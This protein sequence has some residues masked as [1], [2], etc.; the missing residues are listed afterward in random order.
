MSYA[1]LILSACSK[2]ALPE[3]TTKALPPRHEAL[4]LIQHYMDNIFI[5]L[6]L[7]EESS[8]FLA[9]DNTYHSDRTEA[10]ALDT[11]NVRMVLAI[12]CASKSRDRGDA[13]YLDA[14]MH[15]TGALANAEQ[16]LRPGSILSVQAL[17]LLVEYSM[18]DPHHFDSWS[19]VGAASRA[20]VDLGLH[21]DPPR[22]TS[23]TKAKLELRR[24]VY[25]CV[26]AL[27]RS[28]SMVQSRAFSFSDDSANVKALFGS[29][30]SSLSTTPSQPLWRQSFDSARTL[31]KLR[32]LQSAWYTALFQTSRVP[33]PEPYPYIWKTCQELKNWF[34]T[35]SPLIHT[36]MRSFFELELLYSFIY[37]LSP[38]SRVPVIHPHAQTLIFEYCIDYAS[39]MLSLLSDPNYTA[40]LTFNDAMRV[41]MVGRHLLDVLNQE[42][43]RI[44]SGIIPPPPAVPSDSPGPPPLLSMQQY[45]SNTA[46]SVTC[47]KQITDILDRFG[48][49]WGYHQ[50][51]N[52]FQ[53]DSENTLMDLEH[54]RRTSEQGLSQYDTSRSE[55]MYGASRRGSMYPPSSA[56]LSSPYQQPSPSYGFDGRPRHSSSP[57]YQFPNNPGLPVQQQV[58]QQ[59][60]RPPPLQAQSWPDWSQINNATAFPSRSSA[61][62]G[63]FPHQ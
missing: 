54:R 51:R 47:I 58:Q 23:M 29:S 57:S 42:Q 38:N 50:W 18:L 21:Q 45:A 19:L 27:D 11:W 12:A 22:G 49:R 8:F 4:K 63:Y 28:T 33:W 13:H 32:Q 59:Q 61:S 48:K 39:K 17:L 20:M 31:F 2:D 40:P 44:L 1:R 10:S 53:N 30:T 55:S 36:N 34:D 7:F 16:V 14:V 62:P 35:L 41:Y 15:V 25:Y 24:R 3:G 26:Y 43:E 37:V 6:P 46:R 52:R 60:P 5:L 9:V 56:D